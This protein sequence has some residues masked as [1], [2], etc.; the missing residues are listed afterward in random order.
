MILPLVGAIVLLMFIAFSK[1]RRQEA[2]VPSWQWIVIGFAGLAVTVIV[3]L[4][5]G[6]Y[7]WEEGARVHRF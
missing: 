3:V 1:M 2:G 5:I 6:E 4:W 7:L